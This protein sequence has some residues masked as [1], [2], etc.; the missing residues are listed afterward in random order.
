M[1]S[2]KTKVQAGRV[3]LTV[4]SDWPNGLEVEVRPLDQDEMSLAEI[5]TTLAAM[6]H[7]KQE[8]E[9]SEVHQQTEELINA[10]KQREKG[11]FKEYLERLKKGWN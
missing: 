11:N 4:P 2:I 9:D 10:R 1:S 3:E 8:A 5:T 6:Q 7:F